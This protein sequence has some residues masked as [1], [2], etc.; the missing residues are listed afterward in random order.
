M[1]EKSIYGAKD[2]GIK[3]H[4]MI[5]KQNTKWTNITKKRS[6]SLDHVVTDL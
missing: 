6:L 2:R 3:L 1:N 4:G 5:W